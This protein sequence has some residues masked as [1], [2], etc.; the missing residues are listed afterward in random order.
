VRLRAKLSADKD[1]LK[2]SFRAAFA[3]IRYNTPPFY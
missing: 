1:A 3:V 2:A